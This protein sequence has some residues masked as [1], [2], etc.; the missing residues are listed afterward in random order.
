M[1]K[2]YWQKYYKQDAAPHD[3]SLFAQFVGAEYFESGERVIELGCG[4][5]RDAHY[6][7]GR[8]IEVTAVDQAVTNLD[9]ALLNPRFVGADFTMLDEAPQQFDGVY[10]RFTLHSITSEE[11]ARVL[12]WTERALKIGG[13]LCIE[14]RGYLNGIYGLGDPVPG[15]STNTI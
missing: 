8:G 4:N 3:P 12:G 2:G 15:V 1:D 11:Q 7:A 13:Y 14:V 10:S 5:G 9:E 6:L